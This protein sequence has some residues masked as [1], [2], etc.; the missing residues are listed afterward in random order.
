MAEQASY[1]EHPQLTKYVQENLFSYGS[2]SPTVCYPRI[3]DMCKK[4]CFPIET[5]IKF[6]CHIGHVGTCI[7]VT[8]KGLCGLCNKDVVNKK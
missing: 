3:C 8:S 6:S 4:F 1:D 5:M 2:A 7:P